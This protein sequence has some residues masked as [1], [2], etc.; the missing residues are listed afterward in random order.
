MNMLKT[1]VLACLLCPILNYSPKVEPIED[2]VEPSY[3]CDCGWRDAV[4]WDD[5]G[6]M[7]MS[8]E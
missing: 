2:K 5:M 6:I 7:I 1:Y 8:Y 3:L 4:R